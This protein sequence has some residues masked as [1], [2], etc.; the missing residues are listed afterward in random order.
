V[1]DIEASIGLRLDSI[2]GSLKSITEGQQLARELLRGIK[3]MRLPL[4]IGTAAN[5][6]LTMGGDTNATSGEGPATPAQGFVWFVRHLVIEGMT[7]SSTAPD[8]MNIVRN[9]RIVWQLNGNVFAQTWSRGEMLIM[10]GETLQYVSVGTFAATSRIIA[11]G[12]ADQVPAEMIGKI[13]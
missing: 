6:A 13:A 5:S 3:P 12:M 1:V 9:G 4:V 8:V 10:P 2:A 11:H 7:S